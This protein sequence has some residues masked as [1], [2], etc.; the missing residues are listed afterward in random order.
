MGEKIRQALITMVDTDEF[1]RIYN[2]LPILSLERRKVISD[3]NLAT[4]VKETDMPFMLSIT[5]IKSIHTLRTVM[6][7]IN[8]EKGTKNGK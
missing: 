6:L 8:E 3:Y 1:E 5:Q 7:L 2:Y 4:M